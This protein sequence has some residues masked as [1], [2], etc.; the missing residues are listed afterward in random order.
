M[1]FRFPDVGEGIT[2]GEIVKWLVR[3]GDSVAGDQPLV[4]IETD[5]AVVEIPSPV[6]GTISQIHH[7]NGDTI[8][9]GETLVTIQ[10]T[11][12]QSMRQ[13]DKPSSSSQALPQRRTDSVVG[14]L[15]EGEELVTHREL[16]RTVDT[17]AINATPATRRLAKELGVDLTTIHGSGKDGRI[18]EQD[19]RN[20]GPAGDATHAVPHIKISRKYD[21]YGPVEHVALRGVRKSIAKNLSRSAF[22]AV[23]VTHMDDADVT[24]LAKMRKRDNAKKSVHVTFMPY[25]I[26][27]IIEALKEHPYL[28]AALVDETEE[29][30]I[31]RYFNIGVAVDTDDGLMVPVVKI[32]D[33]KDIAQIASEIEDLAKK[34]H[35]RTL[36]LG[37]MKGGVFTITNVG[38]LGG[39]YATPVINVGECAVLATGK[40]G[41]RPV[42]RE[43]KIVIRTILPLS[44]TFDHRVIDG[45]EAARF[46]NSLKQ[47]LENPDTIPKGAEPDKEEEG[48]LG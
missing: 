1:D 10:E 7:A 28:A 35:D 19:V 3:E 32:A 41:E 4:E 31:K 33:K 13:Q 37:D 5:K 48:A 43:G 23:H 47:R 11:G 20:V 14:S 26:K 18:T 16:K 6:A 30:V 12:V 46:M 29:I 27:A 2:E 9:V 25:I 22:S 38:S 44:L 24:A 40:I 21:L 39:G 17:I 42:V 15:E 34:A 8:H 36:D 45:A